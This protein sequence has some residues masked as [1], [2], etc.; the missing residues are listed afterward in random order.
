MADDP[1]GDGIAEAV[2]DRLD[3]AELRRLFRENEYDLA[4][5][6]DG[7]ALLLV[8]ADDLVCAVL[9]TSDAQRGIPAPDWVRTDLL[10]LIERLPDGAEVL[11]NLNSAAPAQFSGAF[12]RE[13]LLD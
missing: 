13:A 3:V 4:L 7:R 9:A 5:N 11:V 8:P 10:G 12:L 1:L 2:A 6:G